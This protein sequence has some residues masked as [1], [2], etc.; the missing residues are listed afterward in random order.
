GSLGDAPLWTALATFPPLAAVQLTCPRIGLAT[1]PGLAGCLRRHYPPSFLYV[2]CLL[3]LVA[4][5]FNIAADLAGMAD[6]V[7]MLTG[8]PA[9]I[10]VPVVGA[11]IVTMT[12]WASYATLA[13]HLKWLTVVLFVCIVAGSLARTEW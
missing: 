7:T 5:V 13:A 12:I 10:F 3:S 4:N 9:M 6:V 8:L 11:A 1:G 2:A